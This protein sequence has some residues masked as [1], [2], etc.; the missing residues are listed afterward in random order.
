MNDVSDFRLLQA[1]VHRVGLLM[2][3]RLHNMASSSHGHC[4]VSEQLT[5]EHGLMISSKRENRCVCFLLHS[6]HL[7]LFGIE[8]EAL[9]Q[10]AAVLLEML[11][12]LIPNALSVLHHFLLDAAKQAE[13]KTVKTKRRKMS[14]CHHGWIDV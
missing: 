8:L 12:L 6:A 3:I 11:L 14:S 13:C 9:V 5:A 7:L 4:C 10:G 2:L 1:S